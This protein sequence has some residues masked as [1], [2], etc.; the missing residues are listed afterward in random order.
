MRIIHRS[1]Q[2]AYATSK[3]I[4]SDSVFDGEPIPRGITP[5]N[6]L[7]EEHVHQTRILTNNLATT[8]YLQG[9]QV[10]I[11]RDDIRRT[12]WAAVVED[13]QLLLCDVSGPRPDQFPKSRFERKLIAEGEIWRY[14]LALNKFDGKV[15]IAWIARSE[16]GRRLWLDGREIDTSSNDIDFPYLAFSQVAVG[17]VETQEPRFAILT[18]KCRTTGNLFIRRLQKDEISPEVILDVGTTLGGASIGIAH[19]RVLIRIDQIQNDKLV[20]M[21]L[22]SSNGGE[23]FSKASPID[24][25]E[26]DKGF[27][28]APGYTAP[29]LDKGYGLHVPIFM[30]NREESVALNFVVDK[31]LLVEAIRVSGRRPRGGLEVF[32]STLG[33]NNVYGD[34]ISDGHGLIMVLET[35]GLLYSSNS[36]AGGVYFPNEALLNHE[37]PQIAAFDASECYSSGL[38]ANYVSMDYLYVELDIAG[39]VFSPRLHIETWD[40]PLPI[41]Q[42]KAES[43]GSEVILTILKDADLETGKVVFSIDDPNVTITGTRIEN[44]R[45]AVISTDSEELV[46]KR[47]SYDVHTLF[48]R[49]YGDALIQTAG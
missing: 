41:P 24:L 37:M 21:L 1:D 47:I 38:K 18:Y 8:R 43:R 45:T 20:P 5:R 39:R 10:S 13:N 12:T 25:S 29:T 22:E 36:S 4:F 19:N 30:S 49:H 33:S 35:E 32:P 9:P 26:Y 6:W 17:R 42:A 3:T 27:E 23:S 31:N 11:T 16:R 46:G 34:G 15:S 28:V 44:L 40:M 2:G 48:H 14:H 7:L